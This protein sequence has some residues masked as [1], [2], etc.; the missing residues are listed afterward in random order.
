MFRKLLVVVL[1]LVPATGHAEWY[2]VETKRFSLMGDFKSEAEAKARG[3]KLEKFVFVLRALSAQP[4]IDSP[5]KVRVFYTPTTIDMLNTFPGKF[6]ESS[7]GVGAYYLP[8]ARQTVVV[9]PARSYSAGQMLNTNRAV[10]EARDTFADDAF[11]HELSHAFMFQSVSY[12]YPPWYSEGYAEYYGTIEIDDKERV[13]IGS[14]QHS[15]IET[16]R[17]NWY[18]SRKFLTVR[19]YAGAGENLLSVYAEGWLLI[20]YCANN[21]ERGAQMKKYLADINANVPYSEAAKAFGDFNQ[22]DRELQRY[23]SKSIPVIV[24]P[25]KA[26]DPGPIDVRKATG[27]EVALYKHDIKL[28]QGVFQRDFGGFVDNVRHL[29]GRFPNDPDALRILTETETKAGNFDR[30]Q[31]ANARWLAIAPK[32]PLAI[33][34]RGRIAVGKLA[35]AK[36]PASDPAWDAARRDILA[37]NKSVPDDPYFKLAYYQS[38]EAANQ[39][40]PPGAQNALVQALRAVPHDDDLRFLVASDYEKR[41]MIDEAITTI[42]PAAVTIKPESEMKPGERARK[43]RAKARRKEYAL[44]GEDIDRE[45]AREFYDRLVAK[46]GGAEAKAVAIDKAAEKPSDK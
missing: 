4:N 45:D 43:E 42:K 13:T 35:A 31:A 2:R 41:G 12:A 15:R 14:P 32:D 27:S 36:T 28:N 8:G 18:P 30:A 17:S 11:W 19:D 40:A 1:L 6:P 46:Q 5:Q 34:Y 24:L 37:A 38:F 44:Q 16:L 9:S 3:E 29:A 33:M 22:L 10:V 25:F 23:V 26:I 7:Y 39:L 21:K 20:H